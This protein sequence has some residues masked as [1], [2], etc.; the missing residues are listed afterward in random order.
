[1]SSWT[2][3]IIKK[4][5]H[6]CQWT[7]GHLL[8]FT[9]ADVL[10]FNVIFGRGYS[11]QLP[12]E[13][14]KDINKLYGLGW[15]LRGPNH[16]SFRI[17]WRWNL[18]DSKLELLWLAQRS[19]NNWHCGLIC[20]VHPGEEIAI[21]IIL[22]DRSYQIMYKRERDSFYTPVYLS[23]ILIGNIPKL[24]YRCFPYFGGNQ[25]APSDVKILIREL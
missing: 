8:P 3:Y 16:G 10:N 2:T 7:W 12:K 21:R 13:D 4:G 25:V 5:H 23:K 18:E 14:Q 15:S 9:I 19:V 24:K 6:F 22:S 1:M 20:V 17:G 11:Y